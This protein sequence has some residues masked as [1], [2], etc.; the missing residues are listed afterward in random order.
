MRYREIIC[1]ASDAPLYHATS[2][3]GA[4]EI[5][6][7]G[8]VRGRP[9]ANPFDDT[10]VILP[11]SMSRDPGFQFQAMPIQFMFDTRKLRQR[12]R[13]EPFDWFSA[14]RGFGHRRMERE[15]RVITRDGIPLS[16][17]TAFI[18]MPTDHPLRSPAPGNIAE[19]EHRRGDQLAG[20]ARELGL[21]VIDLRDRKAPVLTRHLK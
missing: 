5:M 1:E 20:M 6:Q 4:E 7:D 11:V 17:A 9:E 2:F 10:T 16:M 14:G 12:F 21:H 3:K 8:M 18:L 13:I 15:E 19:F